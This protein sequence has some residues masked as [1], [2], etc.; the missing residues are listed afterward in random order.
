VTDGAPPAAGEAR[1]AG[2]RLGSVLG[3]PVYLR[4]SWFLV[5]ALITY[6]FAPQVEDALP[7]IGTGALAVA[8]A[9]A[10][11]LLLSVFLHEL[12]HAVAARA[13]GTPPTHIALDVWGGH[14]AFDRVVPTPGRSL[15]VAAVGPATNA[16]LGVAALVAL[17]LVPEGDVA[18]LLVRALAFANL[19]VAVFNALPGLPLDGGRVLES[20]VWAATGRRETGTAAAGWV[21]RGVAVLLVLYVVRQ[22]A[23]QLLDGRP[24]APVS[25]IWLLLVAWLLWQGAS[26]AVRLAR[27]RRRA[28]LVTVAGLVRPAVPVPAGSTMT[29]AQA[30]AA[31]AGV[32]DVVLLDV[33]GRPAGVLDAAATASVPAARAASVPASAVARTLAPTAT[34]PVGLAGEA[35]VGHLEAA[36]HAE[37]VVVDDTGRVVGVLAWQ[38][39]AR[40]TAAR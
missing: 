20:V 25:G 2:L 4:P 32:G 39:V 35:L 24:V 30:A 12:A 9:Y 15:L 5:A 11:L 1:P 40:S 27:W 29:A 28:P 7:G 8:F 34:V 19:V 6:L 38:D 31:S 21:G 36:P 3:A 22:F 10:V 18:G 13:V 16:L 17:P 37:Y 26:Q 33:Y 23:G 14:T